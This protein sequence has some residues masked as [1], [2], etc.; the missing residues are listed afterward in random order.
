[1]TPDKKRRDLF[2][3]L[4]DALLEHVKLNARMSRGRPGGQSPRRRL[5]RPS[6]YAAMSASSSSRAAA[7]PLVSV[8]VTGAQ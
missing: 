8:T 2:L 3:A 7:G 6:V 4:I 5:M 1:M